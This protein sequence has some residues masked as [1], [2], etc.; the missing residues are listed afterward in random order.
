MS[1]E[2]YIKLKKSIIQ[3]I[4]FDLYP[5]DFSFLVNGYEYRT[6]RFVADI[7]SPKIRQM[8]L[9]DATLDQFIITTQEQGDFSHFLDL[10]KFNRTSLS[11]DDINFISELIGILDIKA[12][13]FHIHIE[14]EEK[15]IT[16]DNVF[17]NILKHEKSGIICK[18]FLDKEINFVCSHFYEINKEQ[19]EIL[20][21][22]TKNSLIEI[23]SNSELRLKSEDQLLNIINDLYKSDHD[24]STLYE[25]VNFSYVSSISINEF[26]DIFDHNEMSGEIWDS[27]CK[28]LKREVVFDKSE[29]KRIRMTNKS[30]NVKNISFDENKPFNGIISF[31]NKETN[32]IDDS[33]KITSSSTYS[34]NKRPLKDLLNDDPNRYF[35]TENV[36]NSWICFEFKTHKISPTHY[37]IKTNNGGQNIRSWKIEVRNDDSEWEVIDEQT[38]CQYTNGDNKTHTF[39]IENNTNSNH[40]KFIRIV[41]TGA[42][43]YGCNYLVLGAIEFYGSLI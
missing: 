23:F 26:V 35:I 22:L 27:I 6:S 43:W 19:Q 5:K 25:Y 39:Q 32:N 14:E 20:K 30:E 12:I 8:H 10:I 31:I 3:D 15:E 9:I 21:K 13:D 4:R 18:S 24:Y 37:S 42:N 2:N 41:S 7:L 36:A 38:N 33:L 1:S 29:E 34:G 28:R 17:Q 40:Y 16:L 11:A